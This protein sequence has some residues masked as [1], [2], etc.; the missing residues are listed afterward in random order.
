MSVGIEDDDE[1]NEIY[2]YTLYTMPTIEKSR[3]SLITKKY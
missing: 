3:K 1:I 2:W